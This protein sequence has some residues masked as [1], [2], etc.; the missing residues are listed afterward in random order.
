MICTFVAFALING[1]GP[2]ERLVDVSAGHVDR[3]D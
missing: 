3:S 2:L 1:L